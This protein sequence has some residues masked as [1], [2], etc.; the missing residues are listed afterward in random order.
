MS[1]EPERLGATV[2]PLARPFGVAETAIAE[3]PIAALKEVLGAEVPQGDVVGTDLRDARDGRGVVEIDERDAHPSARLP[4]G[5]RG[6]PADDSVPFLVA[7]PVRIELRPGLIV[8]EG[9]PGTVGP[10]VLRDSLEHGGAFLEAGHEH[11]EH[12][13]FHDRRLKEPTAGG[14]RGSG[15]DLARPRRTKSDR[16]RANFSRLGV[17]RAYDSCQ[18][19]SFA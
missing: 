15:R 13:G 6:M 10:F 8:Q 9:G 1:R 17:G 7:Q 2:A 14:K 18:P 5:R 12:L 19:R 16:L 11:E 3:M 4:E